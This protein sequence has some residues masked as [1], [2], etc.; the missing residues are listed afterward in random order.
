M[1]YCRETGEDVWG[2]S[3]S[4]FLWLY[5]IARYIYKYVDLS[6]IRRYRWCW[7]GGFVGMSVITFGLAILQAKF[8]VPV[9][10]RPYPYCSP[11]TT[12]AAIC[13]L[14]FALSF[15]FENKIINWFAPSALSC[16]LKDGIYFSLVFYPVIGGW[17]LSLPMAGRYTL[18]FPVAFASMIP[19]M[20]LD[21]FLGL[22]LYKP[23]LKI[24]D[25]LYEKYVP[26]SLSKIF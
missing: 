16:Y 20:L 17:L 12:I 22:V 26:Q 5:M 4:H 10:L 25:R 6:V 9:C 18:L 15:T 24:Y 8:S 7:L 3:L 2:T 19:V 21:K 14:L 1:G 13:A 23:I 11:W